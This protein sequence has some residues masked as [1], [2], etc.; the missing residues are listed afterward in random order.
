LV[1]DTV[2]L[3]NNRTG[4]SMGPDSADNIRNSVFS[5]NT[6]YGLTVSGRDDFYGNNTALGNGVCDAN[7]LP[8]SVGD[9]WSGN[10]FGTICGSV[11][12]SH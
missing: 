3:E 12:A 1:L 4:L 9:S 2:D 7:E 6:I 5:H 10:T 11:P 8:S